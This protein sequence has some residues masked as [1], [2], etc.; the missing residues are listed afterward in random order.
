MILP[1]G[2][3]KWYVE[4]NKRR[5]RIFVVSGATAQLPLTASQI[6]RFTPK[7]VFPTPPFTLPTTITYRVFGE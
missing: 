4:K 7:V 3:A 1:F 2:L 6:V 5:R